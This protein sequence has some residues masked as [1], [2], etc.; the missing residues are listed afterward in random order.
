MAKKF[1]QK[2]IN[3]DPW[4]GSETVSGQLQGTGPQLPQ[5]CCRV[6][7]LTSCSLLNNS[8]VLMDQCECVAR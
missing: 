5:Y 3:S 8:R 4:M 1:A 6:A 7:V 2:V